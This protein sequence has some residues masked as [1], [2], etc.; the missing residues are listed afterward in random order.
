M[1]STA[2]ASRSHK[3]I[4]VQSFWEPTM[5][6]PILL[7]PRVEDVQRRPRLLQ[8]WVAPVSTQDRLEVQ[9]FVL[10]ERAFRPGGGLVGGDELARLLRSR[11]WQPIS[12]LARWIV[13]REVVSFEWQSNTMLPL[14]QFD[15]STM[16]VRPRVADV[17]REITDV[18]DDWEVAL[19]FAQPNAWLDDHAPVAVLEL[20][21]QAVLDAAR[22]D[23]FIAR[24]N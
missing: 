16:T 10:M 9:Q 14:F 19:W 20:D 22:A 11:F 2:A 7:Q 24:G 12:V 13:G 15:L 1:A 17:L 18:F 6:E 8:P 5:T 21:S 4:R 3:S 23:R